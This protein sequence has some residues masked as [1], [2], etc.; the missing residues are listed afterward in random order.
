MKKHLSTVIFILIFLT[1]LSLLLYPSVSDYYN[2]LHQSRAIAAYSA[3]VAGL[4]DE[5]Y[6][7]L[8]QETVHYNTELASTGNIWNLSDEQ[9]EEY[10]NTL[11][12]DS[13]GIMS[14]IEIPRINCSLAIYHGTDD[15]GNHFSNPAIGGEPNKTEQ[16]TSD[17]ATNHTEE[18]IDQTAASLAF[19]QSAGNVA[20]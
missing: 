7:A 11:N 8:W 1:G 15:G 13:S 14:Y 5:Q 17:H 2:S 10:Q 3:D 20:G 4:N 16:P 6:E 18:E 19:L 9:L 12:I